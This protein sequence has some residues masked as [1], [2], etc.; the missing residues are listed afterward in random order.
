MTTVDATAS[1]FRGR[2]GRA[3]SFRQERNCVPL[4][5]RTMSQLPI[6]CI[7]CRRR[8]IKCNKQHPCN[9]CVGRNVMCEFP[10]KFR[11]ISLS[12]EKDDLPSYASTLLNTS[13]NLRYLELPNEVAKLLDEIS[14]LRKEKL[15]V[16]HENFKL[17]QRSHDLQ[18]RLAQRERSTHA[19]LLEHGLDFSGETTELGDK[20]YGPQLSNFMIETLRNNQDQSDMA[21]QP[22]KIQD[23][24]Q[25]KPSRPQQ[26]EPNSEA[27]K[28]PLPWIVDRGENEEK[29]IEVIEHLLDSFFEQASYQSVLSQTKILAFVRAHGNIPEE[30]WEH[31]DDLVLLHMVLILLVQRLSPN[32]YNDFGLS[33][34]PV[35][36][37]ATLNRRCSR[38]IKN[39]LFRSFNQLR[40]N[41][42]CELIVT[43]QAY[44][45]CTEWYFIDLRYEEAWS[46][47]F[48]CCAVAYAIGLHVV[49]DTLN[50]TH[51][52]DKAPMK[53]AE[54]TRGEDLKDGVSTL[55]TKTTSIDDD[56]VEYEIQRLKVWFALR[57]ISGQICS[58]LGRPNPILVQVNQV[59]FNTW[60]ASSFSRMDLDSKAIQVQLSLGFS[61]CIRLSNLMLIESFMMNIT[62]ADLTIL[63]KRFN[64]EI[65]ELEYYVSEEYQA[66]TDVKINPNSDM[67]AKVSE[68]LALTDL[69]ILHINK[70][71]LIEP[72]LKKDMKDSV[73]LI[74]SICHSIVSFLDY[75]CQFLL[76]F[77]E[78]EVP[79]AID[80]EGKIFSRLRM[81]RRF[82]T[83]YPFLNSFIYQ[84]IIVVY[85]LLN[86]KAKDFV[87]SDSVDFLN[88]L[89]KKLN[90]LLQLDSKVSSLVNLGVHLWSTNIIFLIN[91]DL[92]HIN[93]LI[94]KSEQNRSSQE[95]ES[96]EAENERRLDEILGFNFND[97][98]WMTNPDN[99]HNY[100]S[101]P[102][103]DDK[104]ALY[105][106]E[107]P[108]LY[109][110]PMEG[111]IPSIWQQQ[112]YGNI[113]Q[114]VG[115]NFFLGS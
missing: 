32:Q 35:D 112:E 21:Q 16:L 104:P 91:K 68:L 57:K 73:Y 105:D 18:A 106:N 25:P 30:E 75:T 86:Y 109:E 61:E 90:A 23:I 31:D 10:S 4:Q 76:Q 79:Q 77:I 84:G 55:A 26:K 33:R 89:E 78:S 40:H 85:T 115:Q 50:F 1:R 36:S 72:F 45:L 11:N 82:R 80:S 8:K 110:M 54:M 111:V 43:V 74:S 53:V 67:P 95:E 65:K 81:G 60:S 51:S 70:A 98:F 15:V 42:I 3:R 103:E 5:L 100:L 92:Q 108:A 101:S 41:L 13:S 48:H 7:R 17:T 59:V 107:K 44:I 114:D 66:R 37:I 99:I 56:D 22:P 94:K 34:E 46:M 97:P 12:V 52:P 93:S 24:Q 9:Q 83:K 2:V 64:D 63:E 49:V 69:I 6:S 102:S 28:K 62:T 47:M 14:L 38:L 113:S 88:Q 71:K 29:N 19:D 58:I 27:E 39:T 96:Q 20:Y 87:Q